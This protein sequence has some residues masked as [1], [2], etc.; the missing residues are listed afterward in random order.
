MLKDVYAKMRRMTRLICLMTLLALL[1]GCAAHQP[2][3]EP[4]LTPTPTPTLAP[5]P[6]P[7]PIPLTEEEKEQVREHGKMKVYMAECLIENFEETEAIALSGSPAAS[8]VLKP[9]HP[10]TKV[11]ENDVAIV[12]YSHADQGYVMVCYTG[13]TDKRLKF[14]LKG[15]STTY[16]YNL[17]VGKWETFPL[18]DGNGTYKT[19]VYRNT[20]G[21]K[22]TTA[23]SDSI[24]VELEDEFAPFLRPNQYVNY[25]NAT[26]TVA[27]AAELTA[28]TTDE[29]EKVARI[30]DYVVGTMSYDREKAATVKSGYLPV[31]DEILASKKGI[32]FDYASLMAGMLR[33]QN[34]PCKMVVGYAGSAYHAWISVWTEK[35]GWVDGV[36]YFD[37]T[38]WRRMDPTYASAEGDYMDFI[39]ND[40]NY[41][42]K[43]FY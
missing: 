24:T 5:T 33:S 43:Y 12:D 34:V 39:N 4:E 28:G 23:L 21:N 37:G 31:L 26:N 25:T 20:S 6:T 29:L 2:A 41:S 11:I 14:R 10:G 17:T 22:Y 35:Y 36:I 3:A 38:T 27:K 30:Y 42:S 7:S 40:S 15:P 18:S 8:I 1:S 13:S 19:L 32:C 16:T 9:E